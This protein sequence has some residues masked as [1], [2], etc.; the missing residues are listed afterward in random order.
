MEIQVPVG[1]Y[2]LTVTPEDREVL[3]ELVEEG[4]S[5]F[6][7]NKA[8]IEE[9]VLNC[10]TNIS[11]NTAVS[12][13]LA[14]QGALGRVL[15]DITGKNRKMRETLQKSTANTQ[16]AQQ[17]LIGKLVEQNASIMDFT[18]AIHEE[19]QTM[20]LEMKKQNLEMN[21]ALRRACV[22]LLENRNALI[23]IREAAELLSRE[24]DHAVFACSRCGTL[25]RRTRQICT[26]CGKLLGDM[27][28]TLRTQQARDRYS[29]ELAELAQQLR[30]VRAAALDVPRDI[31][32]GYL[33]RAETVRRFAQDVSLP[34]PLRK[35]ITKAGVRFRWELDQHSANIAITGGAKSGKASLI[36]ALFDME[37]ACAG[38]SPETSVMTAYRTTG[39]NGYLKVWFFSENQWNS[40]DK[41]IRANSALRKGYE[42]T[43]ADQY[44][45]DYVGKPPVYIQCSGPAQLR[46]GLI[47]YTAANKPLH[48]FVKEV[49]VGVCSD[50]YPT[51]VRFVD[52][53]DLDD[54]IRIRAEQARQQLQKADAVLGCVRL[55]T[56]GEAAEANFIHR[57]L[58]MAGDPQRVFVLLTKTDQFN[59]KRCAEKTDHFLNT[60]FDKMLNSTGSTGERVHP[61]KNVFGITAQMYLASL[62]FDR[63][64]LE[65]R[66]DGE[67]YLDFMNWAR[68]EGAEDE[69][70]VFQQIGRLKQCSGIPRLKQSLQSRIFDRVLKEKRAMMDRAYLWYKKR[71]DAIVAD[72][73]DTQRALLD[74]LEADQTELKQ[75]LDASKDIKDLA[76]ELQK[77]MESA[78][79]EM[80]GEA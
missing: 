72:G 29:Q 33:H 18:V 42:A 11:N 68:K 4:L 45:R 64:T 66:E 74:T 8:E 71:I 31:R 56:S 39:G 36:N 61:G 9:L 22:H 14:E 21:G 2:G 76:E 17:L 57:L 27:E 80:R 32:E 40:V 48:Y 46:A 70:A 44:R 1:E 55:E 52:T 5:R 67:A 59:K 60:I 41:H 24:L 43:K 65:A 63:G 20:I 35:K 37:L 30:S 77:C 23:R 79:K 78:H 53:P 6:R 50:A 69:N 51:D 3:Q 49:E 38:V 7:G 26:G 34:E 10:V 54:A 12:S 28:L 58:S 73:R 19:N 75:R 62:A 15:G 13:E 25:G 47:K 16:Y